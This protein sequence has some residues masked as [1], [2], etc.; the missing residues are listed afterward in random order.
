M[1]LPSVLSQ[2]AAAQQ[3]RINTFR[4]VE[5]FLRAATTEAAYGDGL[6]FF[7]KMRSAGESIPPE[8]EALDPPGLLKD[9]DRRIIPYLRSH[10]F[11]GLVAGIEDF[12][13]Q[14]LKA[15]LGAYPDKVGSAPLG[16]SELLEAGAFE[17]AID[18]AIE[19]ALIGLF[20]ASPQKYRASIESYLSMPPSVLEPLWPAFVEMK[21]RRDLG[22]HANWQKNDVYAKKVFEA[23]GSPAPGP[24]VGVDI[25]YFS[26]S[27]AISRR[28][29]TAI[30][31][32][33]LAKFSGSPEA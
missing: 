4:T 25:S 26:A 12:F 15:V 27:E 23:G 18:R 22:V 30:E 5:L 20:Y 13:L 8:F 7:G 31:K 14:V 10:Q 2:K 32:H 6:S 16:L 11:V 3:Q 33:C 29:V 24:F 17:P 21:A 19:G 28:L 9:A 1:A